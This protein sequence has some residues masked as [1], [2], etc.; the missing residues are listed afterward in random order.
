M[1][2]LLALTALLVVFGIAGFAYRAALERTRGVP[3][4]ACTMEAKMCP[5]GTSVGR[6][7]PQCAFAPCAAPNVSVDTVGVVFVL[8]AGY[9]ASVDALKNDDTL[10]AVYEKTASS[11]VPH[12]IMIRSFPLKD[13]ES[14]EASILA[15]TIYGPS[16]NAPKSIKEF[17][18]VVLHGKSFYTVLLE[19]FEG[20]VQ[21]AYYLVRAH[22]VLSFEVLERDVNNWME[23]SL[24]V[25]ALK[26][27]QALEALLISLESAD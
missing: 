17:K 5:D 4:V 27:H 14:G 6:A 8:P 15:H 10:R 7:G 12:L 19:R 23:S 1:K 3:A 24:V 18:K 26:E 16:G 20:Q 13:G 9:S 11:S 21:T 22:D 2:Q 25:S